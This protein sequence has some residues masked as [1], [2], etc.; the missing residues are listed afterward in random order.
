MAIQTRELPIMFTI[1]SMESIVVIATLAGSETVF[2]FMARNVT[3]LISENKIIYLTVHF[4]MLFHTQFILLRS[5]F[6]VEVDGNIMLFI[7]LFSS[8]D[9]E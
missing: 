4:L 5:Y 8:R 3:Q 7:I 1:T 2:V 6:G 9:T